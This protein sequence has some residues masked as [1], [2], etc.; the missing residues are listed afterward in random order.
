MSARASHLH[1]LSS[2]VPAVIFL[3]G[4]V[5]LI[6]FALQHFSSSLD[7]LRAHERRLGTLLGLNISASLEADLRRGDT[8]AAR[9]V[10]ERANL[11]RGLEFALYAT[12]TD[13][14]AYATSSSYVG[15]DVRR[16]VPES[17]LARIDFARRDMRAHV[18]VVSDRDTVVGV[19]PVFL[20]TLDAAPAGIFLHEHS[21]ASERA[22]VVREAWF[23]IFVGGVCLAALCLSLWALLRKV[24]LQR[25]DRVKDFASVLASG[26]GTPTVE[27]SGQDEIGVLARH[28]ESAAETLA[29]R[30]RMLYQSQKM[31]AVGR[32]AGGVAHDFNNLLTV[33]FC[34]CDMLR[35]KAGDDP[36]RRKEAVRDIQHAA[37]HAAS[38]TQ[39]LL[40]FSRQDLPQTIVI[41]PATVIEK[42]SSML[43][44][45]IGPYHVLEVSGETSSHVRIDRTHLEQ[46]VLNLVVNARDAMA[47]GG[48]IR[49][50]CR[51][52]AGTDDFAE[53][54]VAISVT[55]TGRGIPPE[56]KEK[57]FEPF[58]TTKPLDKGTGLGLST[59]FTVV[60]QA[61]GRIEVESDAATGTRIDVFLPA[62]DLA[63][64]KATD[65]DEAGD[66]AGD[67]LDA[68]SVRVLLCEDDPE[69]RASTAETL[70]RLGFDV[71]AEPDG[72]AALASLSRDVD[73]FEVLL[74][75]VL[76]PEVNGIDLARAAVEVKPD[77]R[78]V[79]FSGYTSGFSV[80]DLE[81]FDDAV[82]LPKPFS[83]RD[84]AAACRG[85]HS[86][87]P[88]GE[89]E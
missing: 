40:A 52:V 20:D 5:A 39:Q 9:R 68:S 71:L 85:E 62:T 8:G 34:E 86:K 17:W 29:N 43:D 80:E 83:S 49:V 59:V 48:C 37:K 18:A 47:D 21:F 30:N 24:L 10:V 73:R 33:I 89:S 46:I 31:E 38:L 35:Q 54:W 81:E 3:F 23:T 42:M 15:N 72:H 77:L 26:E 56:L 14:V 66:V 65:S 84:L 16:V 2:I 45:V 1:S 50:S 22:D 7:A 44:R 82:F 70:A 74:T 67:E 28:L 53:A 13:E 36:E 51:E 61:Q 87:A 55:D 25:I 75:D 6:L 76:M 60:S 64:T 11:T 19:Y 63:I 12:P 4:S 27:V 88:A 79:F 57:I 69:V 78:I 32:L 58:F 41:Q